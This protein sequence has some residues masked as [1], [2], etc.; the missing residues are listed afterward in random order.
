MI[1]T[2]DLMSIA[3][4]RLKD[5]ET[6]LTANRYDGAVYLCG[7]AIE[8]ALKHKVC[9]TLDWAAFPS[10]T[11]D[12]EKYRSLKTHD[13]EVLLSFTGIEGSLKASYFAEWS[14]VSTWNPEARYNP[15]GMV[16]PANATLMI[17]SAKTL[18]QIL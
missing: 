9:L 11:K 2:V 4:E 14:A 16:T 1:S 3:T 17:K 8:I 10:T 7:Y 5:A 12:F 13:L 6:L 15:V 18:I